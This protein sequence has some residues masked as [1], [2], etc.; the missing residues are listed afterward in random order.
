[1][2]TSR[3]CIRR[4]GVRGE[5]LVTHGVHRRT[6]LVLGHGLGRVAGRGQHNPLSRRVCRRPAEVLRHGLFNNLGERAMVA[7]GKPLGLSRQFLTHPN[8]RPH[9]LTIGVRHTYVNDVF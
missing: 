5:V 3:I 4:L 1:M 6:V 7:D 8:G 9:R 2:L